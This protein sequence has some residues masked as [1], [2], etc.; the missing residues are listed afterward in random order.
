[1]PSA[2][3]TAGGSF[4]LEFHCDPSSYRW[5]SRETRREKDKHGRS[6]NQMVRPDIG[7]PGEEDMAGQDRQDSIS[8]RSFL[9]RAGAIG[10]GFLGSGGLMNAAETGKAL[11]HPN[12]VYLLADQW[13]ASATGYE[14]DPNVKTPNLDRLAHESVNFRNA[15]SV[16]PVCTPYRAALLTGRYPTSTG[17]FMNDLYL[18]EDHLCMAE[19]LDQAGY[20]TGYIGKW[21]LDGHGRSAY[22][23][24]ERRQGFQYWKAAECDHN[25]P[26]SHYYTGR[27][28]AIQYWQGY[29]AFAQTK[30]AQKYLRDHA[31]TR[32]PFA[33]FVSYGT[34][35]FPHE[36]APQ[37]YKA[38]YPPESIQLPTNVPDA[39]QQISRREAQG[40][41][42][43]CTALDTCIG[44]IVR[45]LEDTGLAENTILV[46]TSDHGEMLG[47]HGFRPTF[48][49]V[50]WD[51]SARVPFLLRY[52]SELGLKGRV[53]KTPIGTVDILPT[54][55]ELAKVP[56]PK[57]LEGDSL[58][59]LIRGKNEEDRTA[60]YMLP[61]PFSGAMNEPPYRA[62]R[63]DRHT[64][65]RTINGPALLFDDEQDPYQ[66]KNLIG[67]SDSESLQKEM[68]ARLQKALLRIGDT[69]RP[70]KYYLDTW[71]YTTD[72]SGNI[73]Y[74]DGSKMQTPRRRP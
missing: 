47:S 9:Q 45:T 16:C 58:A 33:L 25:Y 48:K 54:L 69:F 66:M 8:R 20:D 59:S 68:D 19:M 17:M 44:D 50:P 14:G 22:I 41:Y 63:T 5:S 27:S 60:L 62:I 3:R 65:V 6:P 13:R 49:Q 35:H 56:E 2:V 7:S 24:P 10:L 39:L 1:M 61:A 26:H 4:F 29:D 40:Y 12:I 36:T 11:K 67:Q 23:P 64:Y 57:G 42:G 73:P 34:P 70:R 18:P 46:F 21:H 30:D 43:H 15:I 72:A 52:P 37:E 32:K 53:V 38:L 28:D 31:K 71:G 74:A 55:F 51:E